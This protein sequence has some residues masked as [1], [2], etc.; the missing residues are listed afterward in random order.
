MTCDEVEDRL[1]L[2]HQTCSARITELLQ[3]SRLYVK[4]HDGIQVR[5]KTRSGR[6]ARVY[7]R[8]MGD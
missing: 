8:G 1:N 4:L 5:R 7:I 6:N 3:Q 2:S